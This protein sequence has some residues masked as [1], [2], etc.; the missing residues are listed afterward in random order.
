MTGPLLPG[1]DHVTR[2][3]GGSHIDPETGGPSPGAF[4]LRQGETYLSVN[5][6]EYFVQR[7]HEDRLLEIRQVLATKRA[8]RD[9]ARLA[10]LNIGRAIQ[11]VGA[12]P[13]LSVTHEPIGPPSPWSDP[14]HSGINNIQESNSQV[15]AERLCQVV[16]EMS[17]AKA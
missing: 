3:C 16:Q 5:W 13:S 10:L 6:L 17:R 8:V 12:N 9:S 1:D 11:H 14:S 15:V 4:M 7:N 2:L